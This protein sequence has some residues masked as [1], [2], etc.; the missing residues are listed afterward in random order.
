MLYSPLKDYQENSLLNIYQ[1]NQFNY[2]NVESS[3]YQIQRQGIGPNKKI[4]YSIM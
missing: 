4:D 3:P 2:N 1:T